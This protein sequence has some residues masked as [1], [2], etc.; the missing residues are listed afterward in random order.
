[1]DESQ[2][3]DDQIDFIVCICSG[4][5]AVEAGVLDKD[6]FQNHILLMRRYKDGIIVLI[7]KYMTLV[8]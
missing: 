3:C 8:T 4:Q 2:L 7:T 1:M 6:S 5:F